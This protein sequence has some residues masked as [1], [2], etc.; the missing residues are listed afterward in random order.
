MYDRSKLRAGNRLAGPAIVVEVA[1][2]TLVAPRQELVVDELGN[3]VIS[4]PEEKP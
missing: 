3:L 4:N 2:T 1:T